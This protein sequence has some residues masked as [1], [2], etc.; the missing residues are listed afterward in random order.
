MM[1]V[2]LT[3]WNEERLACTF[4]ERSEANDKVADLQM[5]T[6]FPTLS[7]WCKQAAPRSSPVKL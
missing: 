4:D 6:L 7:R 1:L 3:D 2:K 5:F